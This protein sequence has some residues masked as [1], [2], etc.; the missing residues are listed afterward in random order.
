MITI[1]EIENVQEE[2]ARGVVALGRLK[3]NWSEC[4]Q[5][6]EKFL[7]QL[8]S[9]DI[10]EV[11][12][13]PTRAEEHPYRFTKQAA[14]SYFI[15]GFPEFPEDTGFVLQPWTIVEFKNAGQWLQGNRAI[16]MGCYIFTDIEGAQ[17]SADFTFGYLKSDHL[18]IH[19]HHS[20]LNPHHIQT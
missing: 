9:F 13:K 7:D 20:S 1:N 2:W 8:Y 3:D 5:S 18:R 12:F 11:L 14:L 15:G 6:A 17:L 19:L 4:R 10:E 16:A